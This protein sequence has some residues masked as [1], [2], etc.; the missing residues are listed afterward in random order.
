MPCPTCSFIK[1][2]DVL[3]GSPAM[4][5]TD[6]CYHHTRQMVDAYYGA[7]A[8][9]RRSTCRIDLPPLDNLRDINLALGQLMNALAADT[10]DVRRAKAMLAALRMASDELRRPPTS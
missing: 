10:I 8:R 6:Y 3:C 5:G 4:R 9:R 1:Y 7:R 2:D